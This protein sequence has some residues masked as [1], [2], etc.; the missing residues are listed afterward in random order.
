MTTHHVFRAKRDGPWLALLI[1]NWV[2]TYLLYASGGQNW[3]APG[4]GL[5]FGILL[6]W[7]VIRMGDRQKKTNCGA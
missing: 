5:T 3:F 6:Y 4:I 7:G 2:L 1:I